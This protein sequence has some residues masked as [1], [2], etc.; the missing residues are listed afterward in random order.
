MMKNSKAL[1]LRMP[2]QKSQS[3]LECGGKRSA[4]PL[5]QVLM[6]SRLGKLV[7][8]IGAMALFAMPALAQLSAQPKQKLQKLPHPEI[9]PPISPVPPA[10][11]WPTIWMVLA[12][13][14]L[15]GLVITLLL[16]R[17]IE[18]TAE[19][20][21]PLRVAL[22]G[23]DA[24]QKQAETLAPW[25]IAHQVSV[26][27]RH[28]LQVRYAV[29]AIARTTDELYGDHAIQ[30]KEGMRERFGPVAECYDR[31]EFAPQ[32]S[33][34]AQCLQL[35]EQARRALQD[36]KRYASSPFPQ[37]LSDMPPSVPYVPTKL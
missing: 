10:S 15:L 18:T 31:L 5:S 11:W 7:C 24:L 35:I 12:V 26:I 33:T 4:T 21:P 37:S 16:W 9:L 32:P 36:E 27:L 20:T 19:A 17:R 22:S 2:H 34:P 8:A 13:V 25:E 29:P 6:R 28:Y 14:A 1:I 23:L 3:V 30:A